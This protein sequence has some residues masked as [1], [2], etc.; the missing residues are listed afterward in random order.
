MIGAGRDIFLCH[1]V[2]TNNKIQIAFY[3]T[4]TRHVFLCGKCMK[5][6]FD[7][8]IASSAKIKSGWIFA[9]SYRPLL[10]GIVL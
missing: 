7:Y 8:L 5:C 10:H 9:S 4:G 3:L 6:E 2:Q 1:P